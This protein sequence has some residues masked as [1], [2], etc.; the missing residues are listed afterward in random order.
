MYNKTRSRGLVFVTMGSHEEAKAVIE[1]L[2]AYVS[3]SIINSSGKTLSVF[4]FLC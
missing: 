4:D 2:E 3:I 1:N